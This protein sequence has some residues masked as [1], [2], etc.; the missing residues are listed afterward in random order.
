MSRSPVQ[1]FSLVLGA[2]YLIIGLA[3]FAATGFDISR[4]RRWTAP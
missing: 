2:V 4:R 3:G 1:V